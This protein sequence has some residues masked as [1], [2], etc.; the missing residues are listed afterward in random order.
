MSNWQIDNDKM[1]EMLQMIFAEKDPKQ[2]THN[3]STIQV[4]F[5]GTASASGYYCVCG[6][7]VFPDCLWTPYV[8]IRLN[9]NTA[10]SSSWAYH[11]DCLKK[12]YY[13]GENFN[14]SQGP[15]ARIEFEKEKGSRKT[16][17]ITKRMFSPKEKYVL[18]I[19]DEQNK[20]SRS[21]ALSITAFESLLNSVPI[22]VKT[23]KSFVQFSYACSQE[24]NPDF[25]EHY[26]KVYKSTKQQL[27]EAGQILISQTKKL[28]E[29]LK[30]DI[31]AQT[32]FK[33]EEFIK[34]LNFI[35]L[36]SA[37]GTLSIQSLY[38]KLFHVGFQRFLNNTTRY[39]NA[40]AKWVADML[41]NYNLLKE[42]EPVIDEF[43]APRIKAFPL[44]LKLPP[45]RV[46]ADKFL[47]VL[48]TYFNVLDKAAKD[49]YKF[50][51][52]KAFD[53]DLEGLLTSEEPLRRALGLA[54]KEKID[55]H[56]SMSRYL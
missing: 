42:I 26:C 7:S 19:R 9:K 28:Q 23:R 27:K 24:R 1:V 46:S 25:V 53:C 8:Y 48:N 38:K 5:G 18:L 36:S 20:N 22:P 34:S 35:P 4:S 45:Q 32:F 44:K 6:E 50:N 49:V 31:Y 41:F 15:S 54:L 43:L 16:C 39:A 30:K 11:L 14:S 55:E 2:K 37:Q 3:N 40:S 12:W 47:F 33:A 56:Q 29:T 51:I 17:L 52:E 21:V 13:Q 10:G